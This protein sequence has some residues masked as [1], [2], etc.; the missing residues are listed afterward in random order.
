MP[1]WIQGWRMTEDGTD[2]KDGK[3]TGALERYLRI[4]LWVFLPVL[5]LFSVPPALAQNDLAQRIE[6]RLNRIPFN[7]QLWGAARP[8]VEGQDQPVRWTRSRGCTPG[9]FSAL[10]AGRSDHG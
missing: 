9:R 3:G 10:W 8:R 4:A 6:A 1:E 5:P 7:R 2:G